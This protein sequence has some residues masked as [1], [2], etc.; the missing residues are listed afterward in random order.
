MA[1]EL[2]GM[3]E[4]FEEDKKNLLNALDREGSRQKNKLKDRL[5]RRKSRKKNKK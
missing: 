1:E 2:A 3:A 4:G 5:K